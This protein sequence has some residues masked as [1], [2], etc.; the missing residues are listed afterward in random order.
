MYDYKYILYP[1]RA[2]A[3]CYGTVAAPPAGPGGPLRRLP[4]AAALRGGE[5][6]EVVAFPEEAVPRG[7]AMMNQVIDEVGKFWG[8]GVKD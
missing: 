5:E 8:R 3:S 2:M 7:L 4:L 6:V 1:T